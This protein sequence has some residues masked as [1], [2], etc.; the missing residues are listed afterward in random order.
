MFQQFFTYWETY[1][2][3][4]ELLKQPKYILVCDKWEQLKY[5]TTAHYVR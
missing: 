1:K 3:V 2:V 5:M 4:A